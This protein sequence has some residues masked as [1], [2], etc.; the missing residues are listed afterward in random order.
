MLHNFLL[1]QDYKFI[2]Y[3]W[4]STFIS[5]LFFLNTLGNGRGIYETYCA[6]EVFD[7]MTGKQPKRESVLKEVSMKF[8]NL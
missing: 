5:K 3:N 1:S 4:M 6:H 7:F 2:D 8:R